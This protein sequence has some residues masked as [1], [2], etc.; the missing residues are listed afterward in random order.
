MRRLTCELEIQ[1]ALVEEQAIALAHSRKIYDRSSAAARIGVWEC[2]LPDNT[3]TWTDMVYDIFE[4][5]RGSVID[6]KQT[7][8]FYTEESVREL[9]LKRT[10]A[11]EE[12]GGFSMDAEIITAKGNRRWMRITATVESED[13]IPV[14]I[15]GMKQD[16]TDEKN[17]QDQTRYLAN[18]D[19]MTGLANRAQFQQHFSKF[20]EDGLE[21][22]MH[23]ALILFDLD[24]FKSVN[25]TYG[26]AA[27]DDC[28]KEAASRLRSTGDCAELIARIG[29]DEFAILFRTHAGFDMISHLTRSAIRDLRRPMHYNDL[30]LQIGASAG[31]ALADGCSS[32]E[33]FRRADVALYAAKAAGRNTFRL[34]QAVD[35]STSLAPVAAA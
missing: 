35:E 27:G 17:M 10:K 1:R 6:R 7:V 9:C 8:A 18:F 20:C 2:S 26:H 21:P 23:A 24:G 16:I 32:S 31:I 34:F 3:L 25:D 33:L 22:G 14:R 30:T 5:P 12:C 13:G 19:M 15:F 29:G 4:L 28:L 11:I